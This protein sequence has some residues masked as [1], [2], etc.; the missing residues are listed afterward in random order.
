MFRPIFLVLALWILSVSAEADES[1]FPPG[2]SIAGASLE[3][4]SAKWWQWALS[5][6]DAVNPVKDPSGVNCAVGQDGPVWFLAGGFG[7]AKVHR[8]CNVPAGKP[9][10][11]PIVNSVYFQINGEV[12]LTCDAA[13][14]MAAPMI[15]SASDLFAELDGQSISDVRRYRVTT[16]R[17]F[18]LNVRAG[19]ELAK[20]SP[21]ASD[22]YWLLLKPLAAGRH[23]LRF[24]GAYTYGGKKGSQD[25]EYELVVQ[26]G[27]PAPRLAAQLPKA[28]AAADLRK[29]LDRETNK[30]VIRCV[31]R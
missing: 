12:A 9:L 18:G 23:V 13:K 5:A 24:G 27:S 11:F 4:L 22:G 10:F 3:Q 29:C 21:A 6:P 31:E 7:S 19:A 16:S 2:A 28:Y 25:I 30:E 20:A 1:V 14:G 15:A 17:C 26:G 8:S